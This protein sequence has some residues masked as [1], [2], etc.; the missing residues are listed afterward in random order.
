MA[1]PNPP[2]GSDTV[3]PVEVAVE[4]GPTSSL[5]LTSNKA[6]E[7]K[8]TIANELGVTEANLARYT[9]SYTTSKVRRA[10]LQS[11]ASY[12][13][14]VTFTVEVPLST[15]D[16][17]SAEGLSAENN[18]ELSSTDLQSNVM[19]DLGVVVTAV[20]AS[21]DVV[22]SSPAPTLVP[23]ADKDSASSVNSAGLTWWII[24]LIAVG[25]SLFVACSAAA[26][27]LMIR[28]GS[29]ISC[30][31]F[32]SGGSNFQKFLLD[33]DEELYPLGGEYPSPFTGGS[34]LAQQHEF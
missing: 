6:S 2:S 19:T 12:T 31:S 21:S 22:V 26:A 34:V 4:L 23:S 9:T 33:H 7:L 30:R 8:G 25:G 1:F 13:W 15:A 14:S 11:I 16:V 10:L 28:R 17:S 29:R 24:A 3:E 27:V 32:F 20:S 18:T 5:K